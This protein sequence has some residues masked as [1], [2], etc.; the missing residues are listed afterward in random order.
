MGTDCLFFLKKFFMAMGLHG[1]SNVNH[2]LEAGDRYFLRLL[3]ISVC[4][5]SQYSIF[6]LG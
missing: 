3:V 6:L 4:I 2:T 5:A 1:I